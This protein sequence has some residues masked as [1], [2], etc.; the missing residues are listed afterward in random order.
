MA[1]PDTL[2]EHIHSEAALLPWYQNGTLRED[3]RRQV[4]QHLSSCAVCR[5][6]LDE[7]AQLNVQ[8]HEVY[9]AQP[10]PLPGTQRAVLAQIQLEA[11]ATRATSVTDP[12]RLKGQDD[13]FRFLFVPRWAPALAVTLLV[14]QLGLL[15]WST[16][17]STLTEQVTTR[18]LGPQTVRLRVVF[19]ETA[20]E[21]QIRALVQEMRGRIVDGPTPEG[22]YIMELP[23]GG[24]AAGQ[25]K[26]DL[27][28]SQKES[29][30][31]VEPVAP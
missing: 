10:E 6:E 4:D 30:R 16:S 3:E 17:R 5:A 7:L 9:A 18:G 23:A 8:L 21:R 27:L 25:K 19:Q 24:Q 28:R 1:E 29:I 22:A 11:S 2:D 31:T 20:S 13:W 12:Q 26:I 15:L 14:A